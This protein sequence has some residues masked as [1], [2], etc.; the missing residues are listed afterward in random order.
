MTTSETAA[1]ATDRRTLRLWPE[2]GKVLGLGRNATYAAAE[3]KEIK[4]L[5]FG[6]R[7]LVSKSWL[8]SVLEGK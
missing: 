2:A 8:E 5:R 3:R 7:L 4:T 1:T 6:K